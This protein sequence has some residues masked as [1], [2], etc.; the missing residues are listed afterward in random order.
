[1]SLKSYIGTGGSKIEDE[2]SKIDNKKI[3]EENLHFQGSE[4]KK[5][6]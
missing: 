3:D 2:E 5:I 1:L 6:P 4:A